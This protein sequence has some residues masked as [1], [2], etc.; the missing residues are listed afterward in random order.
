MK[1]FLRFFMVVLTLSVTTMSLTSCD[2]VWDEIVRNIG[3]YEECD[4]GPWS[5][6]NGVTIYS[7]GDGWYTI[8]DT[9][10]YEISRAL[11][12]LR[13]FEYNAPYSVR[14]IFYYCPYWDSFTQELGWWV[15]CNDGDYFVNPKT[16]SWIP[17]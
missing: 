7:E 1:R 5:Q 3:G 11:Q 13:S 6:R 9:D 12:S 10:G 2:K 4:D 8:V 15:E 14:E 16:G 17:K